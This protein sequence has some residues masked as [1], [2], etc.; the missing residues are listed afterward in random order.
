MCRVLCAALL[1]DP[2]PT[3]CAQDYSNG[4]VEGQPYVAQW[5]RD[6]LAK[7]G[8]KLSFAEVSQAVKYDMLGDSPVASVIR[9]RKQMF[10]PDVK[11]VLSSERSKIAEEYMIDAAAFVPVLG[12]VIEY[13]SSVSHPWVNGEAEALKQIMPNEEIEKALRTGATYMM[14]WDRDSDAATYKQKASFEIPK[15]RLSFKDGVDKSFI[16]ECADVVLDAN[17]LGPIGACGRAAATVVVP[18]TA[19]FPNFQR[20]ELAQEWGVGKASHASPPSALA[21]PCLGAHIAVASLHMLT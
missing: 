7:A 14:Y 1:A 20:R 10:V 9:N 19:T 5:H 17:G 21:P 4:V 16:S 8:K 18:N 15:N 6:E 2:R 3:A 13:G 12:G 11:A